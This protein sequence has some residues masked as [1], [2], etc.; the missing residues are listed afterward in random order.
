MLFLA[1]LKVYDNCILA[2][3]AW[4][5]LV[6]WQEGHLTCK[7][8]SGEVLAWLAVWSKVQMIC[9]FAATPSSLVPVKSKMVY[10]SGAG[11]PRLSWKKAV[12][13]K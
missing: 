8:L 10:H 4:M 5:L 7:N 13:W 9:I 11:L 2:F 12:K 3:S 6:R 1:F